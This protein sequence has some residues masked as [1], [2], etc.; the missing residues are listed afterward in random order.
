LGAQVGDGPRFL[1]VG[2]LEVDARAVDVERQALRR[3]Q[4]RPGGG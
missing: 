4:A 2:D 1:V 3:P